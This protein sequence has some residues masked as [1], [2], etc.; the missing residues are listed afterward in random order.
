MGAHVAQIASSG[1][2]RPFLGGQLDEAGEP[3]YATGELVATL[4]HVAGLRAA[5]SLECRR[6]RRVWA[7]IERMDLDQIALC[8]AHGQ[9]GHRETI[10]G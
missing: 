4:T 8:G 3:R 10:R 9:L 7:E 5:L 1:E 6:R 2:L